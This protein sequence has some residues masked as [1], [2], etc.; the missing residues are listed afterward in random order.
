MSDLV[1]VYQLATGQAVSVGSVVPGAV[2][3]GLGVL[4]F[5]S[6]TWEEYRSGAWR[7]DAGTLAPVEVPPPPDPRAAL[8]AQL[9]ADPLLLDD[10]RDALAAALTEGVV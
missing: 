7:W 10:L 5:G 8:L 3:V 9:Q 2:P 1:V 4:T 6:P